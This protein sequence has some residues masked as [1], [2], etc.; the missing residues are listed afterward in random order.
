[1]K[2]DNFISF[3]N[4]NWVLEIVPMAHP[5]ELRSATQLDREAMVKTA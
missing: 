4:K 3:T 1:M 2:E 5:T